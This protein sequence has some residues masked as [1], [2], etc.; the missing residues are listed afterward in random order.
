MKLENTFKRFLATLFAIVIVLVLGMS[1]LFASVTRKSID[2]RNED[3]FETSTVNV[4]NTTVDNLD[5]YTTLLYGGRGLVNSSV[6][7]YQ[8]EWMSYFNDQGIFS[9]YKGVDGVA[10]VQST[11]EAEKAKTLEKIRTL[12]NFS[13]PVQVSPVGIRDS[14]DL[15]TLAINHSDSKTIIGYDVSTTPE[16]Q[17]V[18]EK[19]QNLGVPVMSP[20]LQ[21][22]DGNRGF[23]V[24][25]AVE[26][27]N[28]S[29]GS[30]VQTFSTEELFPELISSD[31]LTDAS[32]RISDITD[33]DKPQVY[34]RSRGWRDDSKELSRQDTIATAGRTWK[35]EYQAKADFTKGVTRNALPAIIIISG[36]ILTILV[37]II[38]IIILRLFLPKTDTPK[39]S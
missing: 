9:R 30:V 32:I 28:P 11:T 6:L 23:F 19:A 39:S 16:R 17:A 29:K 2:Q 22:A 33:K 20:E 10:L 31:L 8:S 5:H 26:P 27:G 14:Y 15:V 36:L 13:K 37:A 25:L 24:A 1:F 3:R 34:Y 4:T 21:L 18:Y 38:A 7:V 12:N 35:F